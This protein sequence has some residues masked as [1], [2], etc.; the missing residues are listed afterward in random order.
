MN[1]APGES[2]QIITN[3]SMTSASEKVEAGRAQ[4]GYINA[5]ADAENTAAFTTAY[6]TGLR[7]LYSRLNIT[8]QDEKLTYMM[9]RELENSRDNLY[10]SYGFDKHTLYSP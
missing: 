8:D 9:V 10:T 6:V 4:A 2:L 3:S 1:M 5:V 7:N